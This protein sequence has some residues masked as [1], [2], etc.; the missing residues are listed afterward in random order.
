MTDV[1]DIDGASD[2]IHTAVISVGAVFTTIGAM[3][4]LVL[5]VLSIWGGHE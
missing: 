3:A 5:V 4:A 1:L 2:V